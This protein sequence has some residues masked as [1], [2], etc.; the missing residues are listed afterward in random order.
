MI[1]ASD[2]FLH[3]IRPVAGSG[4][5]LKSAALQAGYRFDRDWSHYG[6]RIMSVSSAAS[7]AEG[8]AHVVLRLCMI[9]RAGPLSADIE[10]D[11]E[12]ARDLI[13]VGMP[14]VGLSLDADN[15]RIS[16]PA[17]P[18]EGDFVKHLGRD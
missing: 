12:W 2:E 6:S 7:I 3:E 16:S 13:A 4:A 14:L 9:E 17:N 18:G 5:Y 1:A 8:L 10:L 11:R 15:R